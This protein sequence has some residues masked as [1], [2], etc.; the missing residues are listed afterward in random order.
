MTTFVFPEFVLQGEPLYR[1]RT[2]SAR[3]RGDRV[4]PAEHLS[5]SRRSL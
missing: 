3:W 5:R 2:V 1:D 4:L